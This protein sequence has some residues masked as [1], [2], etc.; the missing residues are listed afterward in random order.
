MI[1]LTVPPFGMGNPA[2][3]KLRMAKVN[4][5]VLLRPEAPL[6]P[7]TPEKPPKKGK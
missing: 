4:I 6:A 3:G 5:Q 7:L 1:L 2:S